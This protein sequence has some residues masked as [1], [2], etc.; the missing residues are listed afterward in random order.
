MFGNYNRT[1]PAPPPPPS[2]PPPNSSST[3]LRLQH[4]SPGRMQP[5][6]FPPPLS[7]DDIIEKKQLVLPDGFTGLPM[8]TPLVTPTRLFRGYESEIRNKAN[9]LQSRAVVKTIRLK[10]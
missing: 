7:R 1:N 4:R 5:I 6:A 10:D 2:N 3:R 8:E 9:T